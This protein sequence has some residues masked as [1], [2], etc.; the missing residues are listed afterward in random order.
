MISLPYAELEQQQQDAQ[1]NVQEQP[2]Q[3][4]EQ[5]QQGAHGQHVAAGAQA[6]ENVNEIR[7]NRIPPFWQENPEL[8]FYTVEASF[9]LSRIT[10]DNTRYQQ[11]ITQLDQKMLPAIAD[12]VLNPSANGK[13]E[14]IKNRIVQSF[15]ETSESKLR[16]LL[17]GI[18]PKSEK[19][20]LLLQRIRHLAGGNV[21][22]TLLRTLFLEQIPEYARAVLSVNKNV[23]LS[24]LAVQTCRHRLTCRHHLT[25]KPSD[26][27][28]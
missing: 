19:P 4:G 6:V 25:A 13:Y 9:A 11:V 12:I 24:T 16:R 17:R 20:S 10:S 23:D 26:A 15:A 27:C 8:W 2:Q 18:D 21:G 3:N 5:Q 1:H 14:A 28:T 22:D 7:N